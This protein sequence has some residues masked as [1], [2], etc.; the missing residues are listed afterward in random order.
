[1]NPMNALASRPVDSVRFLGLVRAVQRRKR[2]MRMY[3]H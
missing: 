3:L 2:G 1:M